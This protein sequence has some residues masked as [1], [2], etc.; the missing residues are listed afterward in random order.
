MHGAK[1][2]V[3][4]AVRYAQTAQLDG[5]VRFIVRL[6]RTSHCA[7]ALRTSHRAPRT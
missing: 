3:R 2:V 4:R 5:G 1:C 7:L 6:R